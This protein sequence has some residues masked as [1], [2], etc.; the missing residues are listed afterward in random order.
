MAESGA[1]QTYHGGVKHSLV[2][3]EQSC[4]VGIACAGVGWLWQGDY[5]TETILHTLV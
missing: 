1:A 3:G 5:Q 4:Q 2:Q